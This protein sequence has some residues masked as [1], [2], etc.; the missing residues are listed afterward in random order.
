MLLEDRL[1]LICALPNP[2]RRHIDETVE[3]LK[4]GINWKYFIKKA[5]QNR[6]FPQTYEFLSIVLRDAPELEKLIPLLDSMKEAYRQLMASNLILKYEAMKVIGALA[7]RNILFTPIKGFLLDK[8]VYPKNITRDF[9]DIDLLFPNERERIKA[10][11]LL[12]KLGFRKVLHPHSV[13]H[14][15]LEKRVFNIR[16][17]FELHVNLPGITHLYEYPK[18]R[19]FWKTLMPKKVDG[20][21]LLVMPPENMV[22]V[23][24]LHAFREGSLKLKDISDLFAIIDS[25][26]KFDWKKIEGYLDELAWSYILTFPLHAYFNIK[27]KIM[28]K[29]LSTFDTI[30]DNFLMDFYEPSYPIQYAS[31]C[32]RLNCKRECKGCLLWIQ[33]EIPGFPE[34]LSLKYFIKYFPLRL[35]FSNYFLVTYVQK[36]YGIKYASKC[37]INVIKAL[38]QTLVYILRRILSITY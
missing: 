9:A 6:I 8:L 27:N 23:I 13:Y 28:N 21:P 1:L 7:R 37:Y 29:P 30:R 18:I 38:I 2:A 31:L 16:A 32:N 34:L 11:R 25:T 15:I 17:I 35:K 26:Q 19:E 10:E 12:I 22:L 5:L 33:K 24:A 14:T 4:K 36:D 3:I 20:I